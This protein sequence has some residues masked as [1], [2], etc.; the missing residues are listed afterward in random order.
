M[1]KRSAVAVSVLLA[2]LLLAA[3]PMTRPLQAA[4]M[5]GPGV[6]DTSIKIGNINPYSGPASA[7]GTIGRTIAAYFKMLNEEQ[8]GINGRKIDFISYDDGYSPPKTVEQARKLVEN[9]QVLLI[10]QSLGTPTNTA[11]HRY[12]NQK[13]VPHLFV[14]T[15]ASKWNDPK[16]F[17]WT[18]GWQPNYPT[19]AKIYASYIGA[20][21]PQ[22]KIG[23]LYQN[24][25][26]GKDYLN[27]FKE[28]LA[29]VSGAK[30]VME[31]SYEV[32]TPTIDSQIVNLK[33]SGADVFFNVTTPKF[34]AQA[35]KKTADIGWKP[36]HFLNN[37]SV[38]IASVMQP[39][40]LENSDGIISSYYGKDP[41]D[42]EWAK[43]PAMVKWA[44]FMQKYYPDGSLHSTNNVYGYGVAITLEHVLKACGDELTRENIMKQAA[45]MKDVAI[46][47]LL[48]GIKLNTSP[49]DFAPI[50]QMQLMKFDGKAGKWV[51]FGAILGGS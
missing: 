29:K 9:D 49:S 39:A 34:A 47:T 35:I 46:P 10:F 21:Y 43:D 16:D 17:P 28:G 31:Q 30:I 3:F 4:K 13:K 44:A 22:A 50:Q 37:V 11:I 51:R 38:S 48:P 36:V 14:A 6:T 32:T 24:D 5:Y 41:D 45:S 12:M 19:E 8:G 33:N 2:G 20:H 26:Y 23:V 42:P 1:I 18:M 40:G 7:Y 15:G 25:D 27:G